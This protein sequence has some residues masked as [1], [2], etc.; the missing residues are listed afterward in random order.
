MEFQSEQ[1]GVTEMKDLLCSRSTKHC[2]KCI[3]NLCH[4]LSWALHTGPTETRYTCCLH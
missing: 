2:A 3:L 4:G 1:D